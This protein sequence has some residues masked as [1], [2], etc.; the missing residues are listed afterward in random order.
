MI[1]FAAIFCMAGFY[2]AGDGFQISYAK[3]TNF[4]SVRAL[5]ADATTWPRKAIFDLV[6]NQAKRSDRFPD[7][8]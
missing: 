5:P 8:G 4:F 2:G 3:G 6:L 7:G 1:R